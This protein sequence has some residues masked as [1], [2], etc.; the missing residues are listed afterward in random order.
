MTEDSIDRELVAAARYGDVEE[1]EQLM[2]THSLSPTRVAQARGMGGNTPLHMAAANGHM[3][4]L[5]LLLGV[6]AS[7]GNNS[8]GAQIVEAANEEGSTALHW[9]AL[10]GHGDAVRLLLAN[11]ARPTT[12][13][14]AGKSPMSLASQQ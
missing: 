3:A 1:L 4:V 12:K 10:N 9:A 11:G 5:E 2:K 7:N 8:A 13:N 14:R 6:G